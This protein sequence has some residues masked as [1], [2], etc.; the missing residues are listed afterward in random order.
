ML[1]E[2]AVTPIFNVMANVWECLPASDRRVL[3]MV[4]G[5]CVLDAELAQ[6]KFVPWADLQPSERVAL[7]RS[8][9]AIGDL[10]VTLAAV[11]ET[12]R[13]VLAD[14]AEALPVPQHVG[15]GSLPVIDKGR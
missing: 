11:L 3:A 5:C 15:A 10:A 13:G 4:A 14:C 1:P 2:A 6:E 9:Q 7:I 12:A 8:M